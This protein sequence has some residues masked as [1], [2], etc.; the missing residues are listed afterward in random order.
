MVKSGD[1]IDYGYE[2]AV[3]SKGGSEDY[4]LRVCGAGDIHLEAEDGNLEM[5]TRNGVT[6]INAKRIEFNAKESIKLNAP[7]VEQGQKPNDNPSLNPSD[8]GA[9]S[10]QK[11][12]VVGDREEEE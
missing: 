5:Y 2:L 1:F 7:K 3:A 10:G 4:W 8:P 6:F 11:T 12:K 9:K